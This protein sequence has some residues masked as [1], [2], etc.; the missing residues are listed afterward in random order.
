MCSF[1]TGGKGN[2]VNGPSSGAVIDRVSSL[3]D[4]CV[5]MVASVDVFLVQRGSNAKALSE[6]MT[7]LLCVSG[8]LAL[9]KFWRGQNGSS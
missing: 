4:G 8:S 7:P 3:L 1:V 5:V 6:N 2:S 9:G